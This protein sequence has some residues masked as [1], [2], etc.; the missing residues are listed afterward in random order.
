MF[1]IIVALVGGLGMFIYGMNLMS[2]G[3][4]RVAGN[5]LRDILKKFTRNRFFGLVVGTFFTALIQ[6]SSA[7]TV[8][9]VSFVNS[10]LMTLTEASG[11]IMGANIG[12]TVTA[13]LVAFR[14]GAVAPIFVFLGAIMSY[15]VKRPMIRKSGDIVL[16]FGILFLGISAM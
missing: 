16:G 3:I 11:V 13:M 8:M 6:S 15:Y 10:G 1:L 2:R 14:L 9:V 7:A 4:E 12:T 5:K